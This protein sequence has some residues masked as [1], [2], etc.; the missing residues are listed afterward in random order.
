MQICLLLLL[1]AGAF[2]VHGY[3]PFIEDAEIYVPGIKK[4]LNPA[5]YPVNTGFFSSHASLTLFPHL[6]AWCVGIFHLP[7]EWALL[8]WHLICIFLLLLGCWKLARLSFGCDRCAFGSA[9]LVAGLLTLP[10]AG[11]ALYLMD[12]YLN[13]RSFSTVAATWVVVRALERKYAHAIGWLIFA[14]LIHPLMAG[15]AL[16]FATILFW[17]ERAAESRLGQFAAAMLLPLVFFPPVSNAY[18]QALE[19]HPY[20]FLMRW[21]WYEW[22]GAVGPFLILWLF[23][24]KAQRNKLQDLQALCSATL[25][26][27]VLFFIAALVLTVP[28]SLARF[29]ELQPMRSLHLV[30]LILCVISGGFLAERILRD[31]IW[32]WVV[33]FAPLC[34]GMF[35]AQRELYPATGQIEWPGANSKN[36]WVQ[37]F[38]WI[39][40]NTPTEAYF[41]LDP[42]HMRLPGED[43]HGFRAIA[44]RPRLADLVKD[45]GSVTMFPALA[46]I[47]REQTTSVQNWKSFTKADFERLRRTYAVSWLVLQAPGVPGLDCP[48]QNTAVVVCRL[49]RP[50]GLAPAQ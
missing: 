16:V 7:L 41:A 34:M 6:I 23:A 28:A 33:L 36:Q 47:W 31:K 12:P 21:Q 4:L 50:S 35:Y 3:H 42:D 19:R 15:F 48:Y 13:T 43:Q 1:T 2:L 9:A 8:V 17:R 37:A 49:D 11:T 22:L 44:E 39:R 18:R 40:D 29:V 14:A 24:R 46:Q 20:F 32:R 5:L 30:Y 45:S 38:R 26:F 27:G 25:M 10:V